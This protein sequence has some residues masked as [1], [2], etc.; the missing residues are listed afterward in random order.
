MHFHPNVPLPHG[1][2]RPRGVR[3]ATR[4]S[5]TGGGHPIRLE[6]VDSV[7]A[8][9]P[10]HVRD[11]HRTP[12]ETVS[13][14]LSECLTPARCDSMSSA[15]ATLATARLDESSRLLSFVLPGDGLFD[16]FEPSSVT[17]FVPLLEKSLNYALVAGGGTSPIFYDTLDQESR[18]MLTE[19]VV[20]ARSTTETQERGDEN[21]GSEATHMRSP[22]PKLA[23]RLTAF[24]S[25]PNRNSGDFLPWLRS[26]EETALF[27]GDCRIEYIGDLASVR[28]GVVVLPD[29]E[30]LTFVS[31]KSS[32][33]VAAPWLEL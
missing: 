9:S 22:S 17:P 26:T 13:Q 31:A 20:Q 24:Y 2:F 4:S 6:A 23:R 32:S 21:S 3:P 27:A 15:F 28:D 10:Y 14:L 29:P 1:A 16:E 25:A 5:A 18:A 7:K 30:E 8:D 33:R 19:G 11:V 12:A